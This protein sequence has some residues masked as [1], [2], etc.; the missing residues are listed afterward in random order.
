MPPGHFSRQTPQNPSHGHRGKGDAACPPLP[1][2][3]LSPCVRSQV[4]QYFFT[5]H[6]FEET[7][8]G[9]ARANAHII[10]LT[11]QENKLECVPPVS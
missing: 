11:S 1:S 9:W 2:L 4:K 6:A 8:M 7:F 5:S 3:R 10:D